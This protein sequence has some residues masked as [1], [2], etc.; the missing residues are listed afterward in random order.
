MDPIYGRDHRSVPAGGNFSGHWLRAPTFFR[1]CGLL[2]RFRREDASFSLIS[3][4]LPS[5]AK[6]CVVFRRLELADFLLL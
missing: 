1:S 5:V 2:R 3:S 4:P 6:A